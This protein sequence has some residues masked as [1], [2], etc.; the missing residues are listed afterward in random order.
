MKRNI[1]VCTLL[2]AATVGGTGVWAGSGDSIDQP[3]RD[4]AC[5][6]PEQEDRIP[7]PP[8]PERQID[9]MTRQLG[10]TGEQQTNIK[11]LFA[12][13]RELTAPL[14]TKLAEYRKQLQA[15]MN[16]AIFDEAPI[17]GI[18]AGQAQ[19][20]V[21]LTVS[22][23]RLHS[24]INA[25]L[26]P[27]QRSL[28]EKLLPPFQRGHGPRPPGADERGPGHRPPPP[29]GDHRQHQPDAGDDGEQQ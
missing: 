20:E 28:A 13:E 3:V 23:A 24:R 10:L 4:K 15:A 25:L 27:E 17:R 16:S 8:S 6:C 12:K 22:R 18:A 5:C 11:A 7:P 26:M 14:L 29:S 9:H 1:I 2:A 19:V 21:E